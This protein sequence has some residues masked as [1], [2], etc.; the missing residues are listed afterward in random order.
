MVK[1]LESITDGTVLGNDYIYFK[2]VINRILL[3]M[4]I[5]PRNVVLAEKIIK[6]DVQDGDDCFIY[7]ARDYSKT[8]KVRFEKDASFHIATVSVW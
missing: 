4:N 3:E 5:V 2:T 8:L 1:F 6:R 7:E